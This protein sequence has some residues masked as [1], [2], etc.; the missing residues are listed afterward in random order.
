MDDKIKGIKETLRL[1][2]AK[3]PQKALPRGNGGPKTRKVIIGKTGNITRTY[4]KANGYRFG[5]FQRLGGPEEITFDEEEAV[6]NPR[7]RYGRKLFTKD[8]FDK[9]SVKENPEMDER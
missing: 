3:N 9:D 1:L 6:R 5:T 4:E 7:S 2:G 8:N